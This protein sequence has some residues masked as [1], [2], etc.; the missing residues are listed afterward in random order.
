MTAE[1]GEPRLLTGFAAR[2][3]TVSPALSSWHSSCARRSRCGLRLSCERLYSSPFPTL[4]AGSDA[5][6][7]P[8]ER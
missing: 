1:R 3:R 6:S 4:P 5:T 8:F 2:R 7:R